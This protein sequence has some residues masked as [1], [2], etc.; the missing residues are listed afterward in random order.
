VRIIGSIISAC[1]RI[2]SADD[3]EN[4]GANL[5]RTCPDALEG[6]KAAVAYAMTG[7]STKRNAARTPRREKC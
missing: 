3:A 5:R 6:I 1:A 7:C 2:S 4:R